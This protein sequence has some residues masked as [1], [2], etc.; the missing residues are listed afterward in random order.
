VAANGSAVLTVTLGNPNPFDLTQSGIT[1]ALP[2]GLQLSSTVPSTTCAGANKSLTS[3]SGTVT[4]SGAIIPVEGS[5]D[6]TV[7]VTSATAGTYTYT[8]ASNDLMTGPAGGNAAPASASLTVTAGASSSGSS[9]GAGSGGGG[10]GAL[11]WLDIIL[12]AGVVLMIRGQAGRR[13][14]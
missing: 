11:D 9:A 4:L 8:V 12:V 5:C 14:R 3:G 13:R 1:I 2:T 7:N 10:G 6:L